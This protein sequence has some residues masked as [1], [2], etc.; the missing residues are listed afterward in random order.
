MMKFVFVGDSLVGC[1]NVRLAESWPEAAAQ[2]VGFKAVNS[3]AGGRL[4]LIMRGMFRT[5]VIAEN[6]DGV[7]I[8]CGTNDVLLDE[9]L[10]KIKENIKVTLD[11]AEN[12]GIKM[13]VLGQ[14]SFTRPE[15]ADAGWQIPS[16]VDKHNKVL[17]EYRAW[18]EKEAQRRRIPTLDLEKVLAA[19]EK[20]A[21]HSLFIDG[22]H[23]TAEGNGLIADAFVTLLKK[24][25]GDQL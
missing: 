20:A 7:F 25:F 10:E 17:E 22:L 11:Q 3:A 8:L 14:P 15:S 13:I 4:T 16:E 1:P 6:P 24:H 21:G 18:L 9:P 19:G 12:A 2:K 5:D 23:P